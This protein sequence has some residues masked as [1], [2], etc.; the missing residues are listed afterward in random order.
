MSQQAAN[1]SMPTNDTQHKLQV[2][3]IMDPLC[4]WCYAAAP[5][6]DAMREAFGDQLQWQIYLGGLIRESRVLGP[7]FCD[8]ILAASQRIEQITGQPIG[9]DFKQ[10]IQQ[11]GC[12]LDS[13][14]AS[15][16]IHELILQGEPEKTLDYIKRLQNHHFREGFSLNETDLLISATDGL[17]ADQATL[18][19]K[20]S[21]PAT[22]SDLMDP[23]FT[24]GHNMMTSSEGQG[25]PT[26][27]IKYRGCYQKIQHED[28]YGDPEGL[29][30]ALKPVV[31]EV[32]SGQ[33]ATSQVTEV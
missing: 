33:V 24:Q 23:L 25:Y 14:P 26:F 29:V 12:K 9:A 8:H 6:V 32:T 30:K 1:E 20:L 19:E 4:G 28:F 31:M 11:P 18:K 5:I 22:W 7:R 21:K 10:M 16:A 15:I 27:A 2:A 13:R 17:L 3:Y